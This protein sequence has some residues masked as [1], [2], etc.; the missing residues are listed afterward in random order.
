MLALGLALSLA[1]IPGITGNALPTGWAVLSL[2]L[3]L[4]LWIPAQTTVFHW[5]GA[6]FLVY[7]ALS[8][9]WTPEPWDAVWRL[10]Q[11]AILALAFR[12][13]STNINLLCLWQGLAL[14]LTVSSAVAIAQAIGYEPLPHA[15]PTPGLFFNGI[16]AGAASVAVLVALATERQWL[17]LIPMLPGLL[18][19][20][21]RGA[22][23]S[24]AFGIV[25]TFH[26]RAWLILLPLTAAFAITLYPGA[27][28]I[29]RFTIWAAAI[30][31]LDLWGQGAGSFLSMLITGPYGLQHPEYAHNDYIQLVFEFGLGSLFLAPLA[32]PYAQYWHQSFPVVATILLLALV[33]MPL[34]IPV[35]AF[36]LAVV[37]GRLYRDWHRLWCLRYLRRFDMAYRTAPIGQTLPTQLGLPQPESVK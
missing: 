8:A 10:W 36:T 25:L 26:R 24:A 16:A 6:A 3:P 20:Q 14:G 31:H 32:V 7:A 2:T 17:W 4:T 11:F 34:H 30:Q 1:Y 21:S 12:L 27:S 37:S 22:I 5:A 29:Q 28:D 18:L 15:T 35:A 13:G 23:A 19:S 9:L 33:A